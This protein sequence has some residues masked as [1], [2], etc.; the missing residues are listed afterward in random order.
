MT[1]TSDKQTADRS[2]QLIDEQ[3]M[4]D[5]AVAPGEPD[6]AKT[7]EKGQS[8]TRADDDGMA[9]AD[10]DELKDADR[11]DENLEDGLEDSMDASDP[12]SSI[13]P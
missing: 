11:D 4:T 10:R 9:Q 8:P 12:P 6:A 5:M 1:E 7:R 13:Q 2:D 3:R